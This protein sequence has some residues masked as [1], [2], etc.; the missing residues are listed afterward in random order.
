MSAN[1]LISFH[2]LIIRGFAEYTDGSETVLIDG[3]RLHVLCITHIGYQLLR[4]DKS[5]VD[6]S[7]P[8][9]ASADGA[10]VTML[11]AA[12]GPGVWGREAPGWRQLGTDPSF[13]T[14]ALPGDRKGHFRA[15]VFQSHIR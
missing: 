2:P 3:V 5:P 7:L 8:L 6:V 12:A 11:L 1:T 4:S 15:D 14:S 10:T 9:P 13:V